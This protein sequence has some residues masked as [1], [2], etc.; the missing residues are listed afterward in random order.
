MSELEGK[1]KTSKEAMTAI[2]MVGIVAIF[3]ILAC[4]GV[5]LVF[6]LNSPW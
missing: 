2:I 4:T 6:I 5:A 1:P 3:C